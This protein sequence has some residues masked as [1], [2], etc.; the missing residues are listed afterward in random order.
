M[1]LVPNSSKSGGVPGLE[2]EVIYRQTG[3]GRWRW[4]VLASD[5]GDE[6]AEA[7]SGAGFATRDEAVTNC[8]RAARPWVVVE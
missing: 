6:I 5:D 2:V 3:N 1:P 7:R 4:A 8:A